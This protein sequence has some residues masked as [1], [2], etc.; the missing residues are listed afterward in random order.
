MF[1][2]SDLDGYVLVDSK[3]DE[4]ES[5]REVDIIRRVLSACGMR[6][7]ENILGY[8]NQYMHFDKMKENG[9]H[10]GIEIDF[11][12]ELWTEKTDLVC[13]AIFA[14]GLFYDRDY[15]TFN[16]FLQTYIQSILLGKPIDSPSLFDNEIWGFLFNY[17]GGS[18]SLY[19]KFVR[20]NNFQISKLFDSNNWTPWVWDE[21]SKLSVLFSKLVENDNFLE[22][23]SVRQKDLLLGANLFR[24][25]SGSTE[26][27][28]CENKNIQYQMKIK[29]IIFEVARNEIKNVKLKSLMKD[30][31]FQKELKIIKRRVYSQNN[32]QYKDLYGDINIELK[33]LLEGQRPT[34][35][36]IKMNPLVTT[37]SRELFK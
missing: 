22:R 12:R 6:L 8:V 37:S 9:K 25:Y 35:E 29:K 24:L 27:E 34:F 32:D 3:V 33:K 13:D 20:K 10:N 15:L 30:A 23:A 31:E 4:R 5:S 16:R 7:N 19:S 36:K 11:P 28:T 21:I 17:G 2:L 18:Y 26:P 14:G 1:P